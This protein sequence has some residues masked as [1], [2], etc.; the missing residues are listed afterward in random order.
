MP[1]K[2]ENII[3]SVNG[4]GNADVHM[5]EKLLLTCKRWEVEPYQRYQEVTSSY[6]MEQNICRR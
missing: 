1:V 2:V 3:S 6:P 4:S 5:K